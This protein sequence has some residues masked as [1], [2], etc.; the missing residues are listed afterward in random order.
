MVIDLI[1]V[2][3]FLPN[4]KK[5]FKSPDLKDYSWLPSWFL[6][7]CASEQGN[8]IRLVSIYQK[9]HSLCRGGTPSST[10]QYKLPEPRLLTRLLEA[11]YEVLPA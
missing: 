7:T 8:A 9:V 2:L 5:P 6:P 11:L 4:W 3:N 10:H 1:Y